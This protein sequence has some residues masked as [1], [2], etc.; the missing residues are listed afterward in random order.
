MDKI[1]GELR[2]GE[3]F[4]LLPPWLRRWEEEQQGGKVN[5]TLLT[6]KEIKEIFLLH[7]T[8]QYGEEAAKQLLD[9]L[10]DCNYALAIAK[11]QLRKLQD[12]GLYSEYLDDLIIS[13]KVKKDDPNWAE[14]FFKTITKKGWL[15][16]IEGELDR[17]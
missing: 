17:G 13:A 10:P 11:A 8:K 4:D 14:P 1:Y 16:W 3:L 12:K 7:Y 2:N 15:C 9:Q 5:E 6:D